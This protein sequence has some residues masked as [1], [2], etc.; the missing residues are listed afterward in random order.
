METEEDIEQLEKVIGQLKGLHQEISALAKKSPSDAI[1]TFKLGLINKVVALANEVLGDS[2]MPFEG[3][4]A[5]DEE[6]V[7]S[8]SDVALVL[9]QYME[10]AERYRSDH[11]MFYAGSWYFRINGQMT[12]IKTGPPSKVTKK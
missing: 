11:V 12:E 7:P 6:A 4:T 2:Y 5:F 10:E 3:F 9:T 1:N 8:T